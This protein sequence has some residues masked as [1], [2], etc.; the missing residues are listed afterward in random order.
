MPKI[1]YHWMVIIVLYS[2]FCFV[3]FW[4]SNSFNNCDSMV[5]CIFFLFFSISI[6]V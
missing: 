4:L 1:Y 2:K 3:D 6:V 5:F